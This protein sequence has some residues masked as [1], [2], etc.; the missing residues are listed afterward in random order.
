VI[1]RPVKVDHVAPRVLWRHAERFLLMSATIISPAQMAQDL[2]LEDYE[3]GEVFVESSFPPEN[4]PVI[5]RP[6]VSMTAKTK[7]D[8]YPR[9]AGEVKRIMDLHPAERILCH[10]NSYELT[11]YLAGELD[12]YR[13]ISYESSRQRDA[14]LRRFKDTPN[15]VLLA[16]SFERGVDLPDDECRVQVICKVPF[17]YLGDKQVSRRLYSEGGENWY[18]MITVRT[19]V[20]MS[21]RAIRHENDHAVTYILDSQ[22]LTNLWKRSHG[23]FP[24]W[25]KQAV[26]WEPVVEGK[27]NGTS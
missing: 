19:I 23:M 22:F 1:F 26:R 10:T 15:A 17:P 21:G 5:I 25:W 24:R 11:K 16:P 3:W 8:G 18:S 2:G 4:R 13:I 7:E 9:M 12:P 14:V 27:P 20:Q 6:A